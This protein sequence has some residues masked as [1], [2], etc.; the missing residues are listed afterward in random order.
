MTAFPDSVVDIVPFDSTIV[1][2]SPIPLIET[3]PQSIG[4]LRV[5]PYGGTQTTLSKALAGVTTS[6]VAGYNVLAYGA[7][8]NGRSNPASTIYTS[9]AALRAV[10]GTTMNG[11][12]VAL[13]QELD[14]LAHQTAIN[15]AT[16]AGGTV[17]SP[18]GRAYVMT[19]PQSSS[20]GSGQLVF[21]VCAPAQAGQ[22][23]VS[24][25]GDFQSSVLTWP[26]AISK[27]AVLCSGRAS[28]QSAGSFNGLTLIGPG[29]GATLGAS[30]TTM[31]GI[32]TNDRRNIY[33][34]TVLGFYAG[35]NLVG[36]QCHHMDVNV[37]NCYYGYYLDTPNS[38][39]FGN[40]LFERV[41]VQ[42]CTK[43]TMGVH[44]AATL[45]N[46]KLDSC[47]FGASPYCVFKETNGGSPTSTLALF[48]CQF[49]VTQ[50]EAIGNAC[51][52]DD[53]ANQA[54]R[55]VQ[56]YGS[57][58]N[59]CQWQWNSTYKIPAVGAFSVFDTGHWIDNV[60]DQISQPEQLTPGTNGIFYTN[61][62]AGF[63]MIG[64]LGQV[65][66]NCGSNPMFTGNG[67]F[68]ATDIT[69]ENVGYTSWK[70][71]LSYTDFALTVGQF[72][73]MRAGWS[74]NILQASAG[75]TSDAKMGVVMFQ[76]GAS[77]FGLIAVSGAVTV[78][79]TGTV[80]T[81]QILRTAASGTVIAASGTAD[82]T[83]PIVGVAVVAS[84]AS[85]CGIKLQGL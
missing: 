33:L 79:C 23:A 55:V 7:V 44:H 73:T 9:L 31:Q 3:S 84:A 67:W 8:G 74:F 40:M 5:T 58:F 11:V 38:G 62:A 77:A 64:D 52:C 25:R 60:I 71:E 41:A 4:D 70:G 24:W 1:P 63:K 43:A 78:N 12:V 19:N 82:A 65:I 27:S 69:V 16:A 17:Y 6:G 39:N 46:T 53:T 49:D 21:P 30:A 47:F 14:W 18:G 48:N 61:D 35:I 68:N 26:T 28:G 57:R 13:S 32:A 66:S 20:D 22:Y 51:V 36:G 45:G 54:A 83:S 10:Y 15:A 80:T 81:G 50:F 34:T 59:L 75:N 76:P 85:Q 42:L 72:A 37:Q 56:V 29:N 2:V